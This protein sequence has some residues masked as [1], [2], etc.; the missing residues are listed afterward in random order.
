MKHHTHIRKLSVSQEND[1]ITQ[2]SG[3][4]YKNITLGRILKFLID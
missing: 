4:H 1:V 2:K 3:I